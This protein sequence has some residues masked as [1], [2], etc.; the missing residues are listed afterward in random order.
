MRRETL[1]QTVSINEGIHAAVTS[2]VS[3]Q[4]PNDAIKSWIYSTA[5][6]VNP[7]SIERVI[8]LLVAVSTVNFPGNSF[9]ANQTTR[10]TVMNFHETI[11]EGGSL[12]SLLGPND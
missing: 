4:L 2:C 11:P 10:T 1:P 9:D 6:R 7:L 5:R 8:P 3:P 12:L